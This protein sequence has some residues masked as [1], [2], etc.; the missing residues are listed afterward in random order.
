[1]TTSERPARE[2]HRDPDRSPWTWLLVVPLLVTLWP[3]LYNRRDPHLFGI[4]FF[5]W[6]QL[7]TVVVGVASTLLVY[8]ATRSRR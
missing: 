2:R 8:R 4:P 6:Y 5:Y 3:P 1:M 7:L